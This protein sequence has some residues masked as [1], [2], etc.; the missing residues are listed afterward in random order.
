M[1]Q[2]T[3]SA[4]YCKQP[5]NLGGHLMVWGKD[6]SGFGFTGYVQA[7]QKVHVYKDPLQPK[8][9]TVSV[10]DSKVSRSA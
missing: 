4:E 5:A 2:L 1:P 3:S 9:V 7:H 6:R 8:E 10:S